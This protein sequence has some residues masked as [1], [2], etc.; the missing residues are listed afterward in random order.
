MRTVSEE[1]PAPVLSIIAPCFNEADNLRELVARSLRVL[2]D[3]EIPGEILLVDDGSR[4]QTGAVIRELSAKF[5][6]RVRGVAHDENLGIEASWRS[7]LNASRGQYACFLD[8]DLQNQPE[9]AARLFREIRASNADVVQGVR[10]HIGKG[11][12]GRAQLSI[13]LNWLL[14]VSFGMRSRDN[15]SGF[16][17][18]R[19]EVLS[20]IL[21]HRHRYRY[22]Q[23][24]IS[25]AATARG[26]SVR[27]VETLFEPRIHGRSFLGRFPLRV[28]LLCLV[29]VAKAIH[30]YRFGR[31]RDRLFEEAL[32]RRLA[33]SVPPP[34]TRG[35][36]KAWLSFYLRLMPFHHWMI[37]RTAGYYYE[38]LDRTQWLERQALEELQGAKLRRLL[39]HAYWHVPYYRKVMD[40]LDIGPGDIR[41]I[42]DLRELPLLSK[43]TVRQRFY[44]DL[45]SDHH[46][47]RAVLRISTSGSTGEPLSCWVDRRQLELR[48]AATLRGLEWAGY[49]FG[50]RSVR[51]WHQN[52]GMDRVQVWKEKLDSRL[53]RRRL[54][55]AFEFDA[56]RVKA[57]QDVIRRHRPRLVEGYAESFHYLSRAGLDPDLRALG[58]QGV[59][60]SAQTLDAE[61]RSSIEEAFGARVFDKY[62]SREF[63]GIA[64]E[65][66]EGGRHVVAESYIVEI[67]VDG[68]PARPGELGEVVVT[69]L[70]N[71]VMPFVRY[72]IG[73]L[74]YAVDDR[75]PCPCGRGLPRMGAIEGRVQSIVLGVNGRAVPSSFFFHLLKDYGYAVSRFQI[76]Q[77]AP[78]RIVFRYVPAD[79][80]HPR[81][82][83]ELAARMRRGLGEQMLIERQPVDRIELVRTGKH[84]AV[85]NRLPLK[86]QTLEDVLDPRSCADS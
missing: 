35:L 6:P 44:S 34:V 77:T 21:S 45:L 24:F 86:Y 11:E 10:R 8:A 12:R 79:R 4:D 15:K 72:Q 43:E 7:G 38:V 19:R 36:R 25:V 83:E 22:F 48:W 62:G 84:R 69:D 73:D 53:C 80:F 46:D 81:V 66:A 18:A 5:A 70:N 82:L 17:L 2:D 3:N 52:L 37:T 56:P 59:V 20:E 1:T 85:V 64:Y 30:E 75:D 40:E 13:G 16:V 61:S 68:R 14:N 41:G 42:E 57:M 47:K 31:H 54:V 32:E 60:S 78:G 71:F 76:E 23:T 58:I 27:E 39:A 63:S 51:L 55:P 50:D 74:A 65:C 67:L 33:S 49:R 29:D 26:F 28:I 9:D